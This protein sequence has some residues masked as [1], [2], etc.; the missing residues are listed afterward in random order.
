[1]ARPEL[2]PQI[3]TYNGKKEFVMP[4]GSSYALAPT[5]PDEIDGDLQYIVYDP[6]KR[7]IDQRQGRR[8]NVNFHCRNGVVFRG[9][10]GRRA[11]W[12]F[13]HGGDAKRKRLIQ[14]TRAKALVRFVELKADS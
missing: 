6:E 8:L 10:D 4:V 14:K 9:D 13:E 5:S 7:G 1:M 3:E 12:F 11:F 2:D